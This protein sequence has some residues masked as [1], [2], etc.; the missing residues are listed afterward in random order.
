[1]SAL[2]TNPAVGQYEPSRRPKRRWPLRLLVLLVTMAL[3][4]AGVVLYTDFSA[5]QQTANETV[6]SGHQIPVVIGAV[7][8]WD[9]EEARRTIDAQSSKLDVAS[10]W[11]YSVAKDGTVVLQP[12]L[13][14]GG[15]AAQA[16]WLHDRGLKVIPTIA[17]T[18]E[19]L[20]D[21]ETVSK[22][23]RDGALRGKHV[24]SIVDLVNANNY[25]GIQIDYE[26]LPAKDR[27]AFSA[28]V[29]D[30]G[31]AL[32]AANKLLYVT[33]HVK[34]DDAG[35]DDRNKA[36]DYAAIGKA[37][38][39][40]CL[41][42]YDWHWSTGPAGPIAPYNWVE[43]VIRY[44]VTQIPAEKI[45]L[46]VGLFGYD[47]VGTQAQNLTWRQV[48]ALAAQYQVDELWDVGGQ[49]PHFTYVDADGNKHEVWYENGRSATTKFDLA[50]RYELGGIELWRMGGEDPSVWEP[51]P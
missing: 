31:A 42:A 16:T 26:D 14:A 21:P 38:D 6:D 29:T 18:T 12:G 40:V 9:E 39:M 2:V 17:N 32:H 37:A 19:G 23:I 22:V 1:V 36:Q 20:W 35:Y 10:P 5:S 15:E 30:L 25:D 11:S 41:M 44:S 51:G 8:Y 28:F 47:W 49:S 7:P 34:E 48:V 3:L 43:R 46:G 33:V 24:Q 27:A 13:D 4:A 50:R 45:I